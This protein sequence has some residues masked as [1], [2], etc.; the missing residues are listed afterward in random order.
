MRW[1][2]FHSDTQHIPGIH[3]PFDTDDLCEYLRYRSRTTKDFSTILSKLKKMGECCNQILHNNI[4]QQPSLQYQKLISQIRALKKELRLSGIDDQPTNATVALGNFTISLLLAALSCR[5]FDN[6]QSLA[7][8]H[9][10]CLTILI[11]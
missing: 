3:Q 8:V 11:M 10:E 5:S 6:F 9:R 1:I 4:H 2:Q 7:Q